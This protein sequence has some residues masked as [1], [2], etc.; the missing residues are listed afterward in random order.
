MNTLPRELISLSQWVGWKHEC[1]DGRPTKIPINPH[2]GGRASS[3]DARTWTDYP[4]AIRAKYRYRL[5]GIGFV[6]SVA[7]PLV[8]IDLDNC[9]NPTTGEIAP[10]ALKIVR[11]LNSFTE[12]S[13]SGR[14]LH[15]FVRGK[16]PQEVI[17]EMASSGGRK[18]GG[19]EMYDRTRYFTIT[20]N[21]LNGTPM[22]IEE[23]SSEL[24]KLH[25]FFFAAS[26]KSIR[27]NE[28]S[29]P[30]HPVGVSDEKILE[31][32]RRAANG[33]RFEKLWRGEWQDIYPSQ[34]EA[35]LAL[36]SILA[37]W[38]GGDAG[39]V[40]LLFRCS[41]LMRPKWDQRHFNDGSTYGRATI[42]KAC[43]QVR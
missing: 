42:A 1:R 4:T 7:D 13:P 33:A 21:H 30:P 36:C 2:T 9:R 8:G 12:I 37:F 32:A 43:R 18:K 6:F 29:R 16:L 25:F 15:I 17:E 40:D 34:S 24:E 19:I 31:R 26:K 27:P 38:T 35:D 20:G 22:T 11:L 41:G 10:R 14:G 23:R 5:D 3:I 28:I 39:R